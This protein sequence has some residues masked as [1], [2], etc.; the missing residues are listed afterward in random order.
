MSF[1]SYS[2]KAGGNITPARFI[3]MNDANQAVTASAGTDKCC[4]VAHESIEDQLGVTGSATYHRTANSVQSIEFYG[5][6]RVCLIEAGAAV[7]APAYLKSDASGRGIA[8][9]TGTYAGAQ[10]LEDASGA[11]EL[12][13]VRVT[14]PIYVP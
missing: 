9:T 1:E 10:A 2:L 8:A 5:P 3:V 13:R 14:D 12:I 7:T 11:G 6:G 4:G